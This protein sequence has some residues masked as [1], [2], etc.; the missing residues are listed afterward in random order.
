[1]P[2]TRRL[3]GGLGWTSVNLGFLLTDV[4]VELFSRDPAGTTDLDRVDFA[5]LDQFVEV[6]ATQREHG[7]HLLNGVREFFWLWCVD[8]HGFKWPCRFG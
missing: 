1:M 5:S 3:R 2:F 8:W 7:R 6:G 4:V